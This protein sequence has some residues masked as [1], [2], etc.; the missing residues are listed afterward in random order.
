[1]F[2]NCYKFNSDL[3]KWNV[4]SG[5]YFSAMFYDCKKFNA[6]LSNWDVSNGLIF[7]YMFAG[8]DSFNADLSKWNVTNA[9]EYNGFALG[10]LLENYPERI[11]A[12][13]RSKFI[14]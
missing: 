7:S 2:K 8:C 9:K 4:S 10:S 12:K 1:M 3:S 11:P 5:L 6:D 14:K 13:F